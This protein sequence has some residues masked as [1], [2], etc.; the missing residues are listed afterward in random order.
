MPRW[1]TANPESIILELMTL[2][3]IKDPEELSSESFIAARPLQ[4]VGGSGPRGYGRDIR[5]T[6]PMRKGYFTK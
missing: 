1:W 4:C 2:K 6:S 3:T 5:R